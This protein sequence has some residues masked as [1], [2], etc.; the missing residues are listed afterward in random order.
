MQIARQRQRN[1]QRLSRVTRRPRCER[2]ALL[3][4]QRPVRPPL[5]QPAVPVH[6]TIRI[7]PRRSLTN[8]RQRAAIPVADQAQAKPAAARANADTVHPEPRHQTL[9]GTAQ[10]RSASNRER[11]VGRIVTPQR[12]GHRTARSNR[13]GSQPAHHRGT[14]NHRMRPHRDEHRRRRDH[15]HRQRVP[16][17]AQHAP[18][19]RRSQRVSP[20]RQPSPAGLPIRLH[21][22]ESRSGHLST[23]QVAPATSAVMDDT[24]VHTHREPV[25][26]TGDRSPAAAHAYEAPA[27]SLPDPPRRQHTPTPWTPRSSSAASAATGR[28]PQEI[29]AAAGVS[30][31][32]PSH[33]FGSQDGLYMQ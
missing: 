18:R 11:P 5:T 8:P 1:R 9:P 12:I 31:G 13:Q 4:P 24:N 16:G 32:T 10:H 27:R 29:S 6:D 3:E 23:R 25:N 19:T 21:R 15:H 26:A 17:P 30:R 33:F 14:T 20:T 7:G 22:C 28:E 2:E